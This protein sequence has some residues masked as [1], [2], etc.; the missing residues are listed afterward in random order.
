MLL[1]MSDGTDTRTAVGASIMR[2]LRRSNDRGGPC[3]ETELP[4]DRGLPFREIRS[5]R[6]DTGL[7]WATAE[8]ERRVPAGSGVAL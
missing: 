6:V 7:T 1:A 2:R 4:P 8:R 3:I 5:R